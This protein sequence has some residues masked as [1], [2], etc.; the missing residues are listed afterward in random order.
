ML[1]RMLGAASA[2]CGAMLATSANAL[3]VDFEQF[4]IGTVLS[5]RMTGDE[6]FLEVEGVI[7]LDPANPANKVLALEMWPWGPLPF[8]TVNI[9]YS[10]IN[11]KLKYSPTVTGL[12]AY[13]T[14]P[15]GRYRFRGAWSD[16]PTS[17]WESFAFEDV[18]LGW[19]SE[20]R[21]YATDVLV[22]NITYEKGYTVVPEPATWA[23]MVSGFGVLGLAVR[24]RR[25]IRLLDA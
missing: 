2:V 9:A 5:G 8:G 17:G 16:L 23:L 7:V 13:T 22:D 19:F 3:V 12:D 10:F 6:S 14:D 11:P 4:E 24:R 20:H 25:A 15:G 18:A 21:F 1:V